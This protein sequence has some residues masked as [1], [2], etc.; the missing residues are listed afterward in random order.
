MSEMNANDLV[1]RY[2]ALRDRK[3]QYKAEYDAKVADVERAMDLIETMLQKMMQDMGVKSLRTDN[4]TPYF[5]TQTSATVADW[6]AY[7]AWVRENDAWEFLEK[8]VNKTSVEQ[9]KAA[10]DD[11][12]PGVNWSERVKV[13]VKAS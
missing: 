5:T 6:D 3:A 13:N 1:G 4:G 11:L 12:P 8:R 9:F 7:L 2:R 10:N